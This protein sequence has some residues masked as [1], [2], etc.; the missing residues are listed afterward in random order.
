MENHYFYGPFSIVMLVYRRVEIFN[1]AS[2]PGVRLVFVSSQGAAFKKEI[3][4]KSS[5]EEGL[6]T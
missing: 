5:I 4:I 3:G 1:V 6:A 2:S